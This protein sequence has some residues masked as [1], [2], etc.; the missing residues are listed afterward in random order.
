V[1]GG[2]VYVT[3]KK[4]NEERVLCLDAGSG[5]ELWSYRYAVDYDKPSGLDNRFKSGP[6]ATPTVHDGRVYTVGT[7]GV[8]LC[9]KAAPADGKAHLLWRHDLL[10][11]YDAPLPKWGVACSPLVEGA[12]LIVQPGGKRGS[13]VA[14]D[15]ATGE[16]KWTALDDPSGYSSPVAG[17]GAGV[18]QLVCFTAKRMVGLRPG[19]GRLLWQYLWVTRYDANIATP[20][21]A[22]N[23]VFLSSDYS[24]GCALLELETRGEALSPREVAVRNNKLMRNQFSTCVLYDNHLYGFD[25]SGAG[26][27][28]TLRCVDVRAFEEKWS[29]RELEKGC[30]L[31]ADGHLLVLTEAGELA[32]VEATPDGY[33]KKALAEV[34]NGEQCWALPALAGG[35]LY[36]RDNKNVICLDLKKK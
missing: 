24:H 16:E 29:T 28:G 8:L 31:Y 26:G 4:G 19:D 32:L 27:E 33:R 10:S 2:R 30:L 15:R 1:A 6:R 25:V 13:V 11:K 18:P 22:D 14:F 34:L 36:L 9:L 35:R 7:T 20:V 12:L 23:Y 17:A 21:V 5:K 3:D